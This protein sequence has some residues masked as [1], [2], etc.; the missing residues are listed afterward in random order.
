MYPHAFISC[1]I[2]FVKGGI[3]A[4]NRIQIDVDRSPSCSIRNA[5][6]IGYSPE[7]RALAQRAHLPKHCVRRE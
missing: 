4:D 6:I 5:A 7:Y 1:C 2:S 3:F